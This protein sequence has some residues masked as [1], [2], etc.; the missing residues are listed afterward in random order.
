MIYVSGIKAIEQ[1]AEL[2]KTDREFMKKITELDKRYP[3]YTLF[4]DS[5]KD[6]FSLRIVYESGDKTI[7]GGLV[8][9]QFDGEWCI[10]T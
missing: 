1:V 4:P 3:E 2:V 8:R 6:A 10:H 7:W 5:Y 9:D